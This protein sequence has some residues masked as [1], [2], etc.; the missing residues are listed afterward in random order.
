VDALK[1]FEDLIESTIEGSLAEATTAFLQPV[2]IAKKLARA[3]DSSDTIGV[4]K[5]LAPNAYLVLVSQRDF[6]GLSPFRRTLERELAAYVHA[7][8]GERGLSFVAAPHVTIA[9]GPTVRPRRVLVQAAVSDVSDETAGLPEAG[10]TARL[11]VAEVRA[12]LGRTAQIALPDGRSI[13]LDKAVISLGRQLDNDVVIEDT[14]VSRHH[15]HLRY[16]HRSYCLYDLTSANGTF[17]NGQR[18]EQVV[19]RDGDVISLGGLELSFR[20]ALKEGKRGA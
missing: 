20:R 7:A 9:V 5:R 14:R 18:I 17:V 12:L 8:A 3:L 13:T 16:E 6:D 15:A 19:L 4:D 11:P 2:E 10:F 1:R